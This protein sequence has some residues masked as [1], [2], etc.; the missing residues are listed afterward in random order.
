[1]LEWNILR[2]FQYLISLAFINYLVQGKRLLPCLLYFNI[3][4]L[5]LYFCLQCYLNMCMN[6]PHRVILYQ[7]KCCMIY[8]LYLC[9]SLWIFRPNCCDISKSMFNLSCTSF[10][11]WDRMAELSM[12]FR[13]SSCSVRAHWILFLVIDIVVFIIQQRIIKV[14]N[15]N[16]AVHV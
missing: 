14:T 9:Q 13:S 3:L 5:F 16:S 2:L 4:Y 7:G 1:M 12:K 6:L 11:V 10:C 8:S 15:G